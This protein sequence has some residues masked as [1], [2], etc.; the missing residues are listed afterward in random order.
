MNINLQKYTCVWTCSIFPT[1]QSRTWPVQGQNRVFPVY[2]SHTG[3][4][5]VSLQGSQVMDTG[6]D[7]WVKVHREKSVNPIIIWLCLLFTILTQLI[8]VSIKWFCLWISFVTLTYEKFPSL[9][10]KIV[11]QPYL[12]EYNSFVCPKAREV[13]LRKCHKTSICNKIIQIWYI[14]MSSN[15]YEKVWKTIK[16]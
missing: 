15:N 7:L 3:K 12:Y 16:K 10:E 8:S 14:S 4:I 6:F 5:L 13:C 2:F 9:I 1:L 11:Y